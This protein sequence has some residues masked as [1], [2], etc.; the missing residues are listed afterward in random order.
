LVLPEATIVTKTLTH[1]H[2]LNP[3]TS[4]QKNVRASKKNSPKAILLPPPNSIRLHTP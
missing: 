3:A 1:T 2:H 4:I